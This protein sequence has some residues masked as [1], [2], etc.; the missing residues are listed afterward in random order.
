MKSTHDKRKKILLPRDYLS[1]SAFSTF[2]RSKEEYIRHYFYG[3]PREFDS[4]YIQFGKTFAECL[5]SKTKYGD[6][7]V[8][9][10]LDTITKLPKREHDLE[11]VM[12]SEWGK[13]RLLARLDQYDHKS[14]AFNEIK[15]GK[16]KWTHTM[17][18]NHGQ[19]KFYAL[20]LWLKT[21]VVKQKKNLIWIETEDTD[22][23][24]MPTGKI[25]Y[26]PVE[27]N[28][29]ELMT[30]GKEIIRVAQEISELY[31]QHIKQAIQ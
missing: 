16:R 1:W 30:F 29:V 28:L 6:P 15:T 17:A 7:V 24:V 12:S 2:K 19:L 5:E 4:P 10:V 8:D 14:H 3:E 31:Q 26:F 9:M 13:I 21:G 11:A 22:D 27:Y 20:I 25:K 23:G 18:K